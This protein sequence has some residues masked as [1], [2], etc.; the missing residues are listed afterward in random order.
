MIKSYKDLE[1]YNL[2]YQLAMEIFQL[3]KK[4]PKEELYSLSSQIVRSSRSV[5]ANIVEVWA[6]RVYENKLKV[7]LIDVLG[8]A[9]ETQNWI[10]FAKD[11]NYLTTEEFNSLNDKLELI[12]KMLTKLHQNWKTIPA[13]S[14]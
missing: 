9:T 12:G 5:S 8:S 7:H 3:T 14:I 4:F 2:S 13:S 1:V 6:K 11:C 10:L